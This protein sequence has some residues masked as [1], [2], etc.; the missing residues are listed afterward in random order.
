METDEEASSEKEQSDLIQ[1]ELDWPADF[2]ARACK[3]TRWPRKAPLVL[4]FGADHHLHHRQRPEFTGVALADPYSF[5]AHDARE[6][7]HLLDTVYPPF[8]EYRRREGLFVFPCPILGFRDDDTNETKLAELKLA[9]SL[10][11]WV[12][13]H[14][15]RKAYDGTKAT[16]T[17]N[18]ALDLSV[19]QEQWRCAGVQANGFGAALLF[20][21]DAAY[22][23]RKANGEITRKVRVKPP[24]VSLYTAAAGLSSAC[25]NA[26]PNSTIWAMYPVRGQTVEGY[27]QDI[28]RLGGLV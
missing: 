3:F 7:F 16:D 23:E 14:N 25:R 18:A 9:L 26:V 11:P 24:T 2:A 19:K 10:H 15:W 22:F 4:Y 17:G 12:L 28:K 6:A 27:L 21:K 13:V 5:T 20:W 8:G 1:R